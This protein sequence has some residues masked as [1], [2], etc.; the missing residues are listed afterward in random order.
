MTSRDLLVVLAAAQIVA[1]AALL[2]AIFVNRWIR[3]RRRA[4]VRPRRA[5][6]DQA[7][8]GWALGEIGPEL[9]ARAL[10]ALPTPE[11]VE[12]L[13]GWAGRLRGERWRALA[14]ALD[15]RPW[16]ARLRA[17]VRARRWWRRLQAARFLSVAA[18][19]ADAPLVERLLG[20]AQPAV[21]IA[22]GAALERIA[23][24]HLV[25]LVIERM[26]QMAGPVQAHYASVLRT[27]HAIV[28][29]LLVER[30]GRV[31]DPA[32]PRIV[33]FAGR[34]ADA[35]LREAVTALANHPNSEVRVQVARALGDFPHTASVAALRILSTDAAWE[36]RAQAVRALGRIADP[37]T[38]PDLVARLG[39][40]V[41]WVRLRAALALTRLGAGG[42]DALLAAEIGPQPDAR[43]VA[44]LILGL[45]PQALTE[46]AA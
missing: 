2:I 43:S 40:A 20:D 17:A 27:A 6:L 42:R 22:A 32:L 11:A 13:V 4:G 29:P 35:G 44:R 15:Q 9:V 41:W 34:L 19:P 38:L 10:E 46:F 33:E 12:A 30:L 7:M 23:T 24:P 45:T 18:T 28:V 16:T 39:D 14:Q 26:P 36:V 37:A 3:Q 25:A 8:N 31:Y 1:L 21:H 5:V